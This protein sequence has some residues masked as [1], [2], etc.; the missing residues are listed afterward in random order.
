MNNNLVCFQH[1]C[2]FNAHAYRR[3]KS[4]KIVPAGDGEY[5]VLGGGKDEYVRPK[6]VH[7]CQQA[8]KNYRSALQRVWPWDWSGDALI[9]A[10]EDFGWLYYVKVS[11]I[12]TYRY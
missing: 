10:M 1:F 2:S 8:M 3:E 12:R 5:K 4:S 11:L 9:K 7:E 6:S